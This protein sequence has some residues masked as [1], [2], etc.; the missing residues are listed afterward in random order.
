MTSPF[1]VTIY[2]GKAPAGAD[3]NRDIQWFCTS[4]GLVGNRD[5][6][7]STFRIFVA[8]LQARQKDQMLSSDNI[9]A[10]AA[11][12]RATVIHH[13]NKLAASGLVHEE[14]ERYRL[15]VDSMEALVRHVQAEINVSLREMDAVS[16]RIDRQ[17]GLR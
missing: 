16:K 8:L 2:R 10:E 11:L 1:R 9:A 14:H 12:S 3:L 6:N 7:L 17:L 5:K 15:A 4:L 13:L